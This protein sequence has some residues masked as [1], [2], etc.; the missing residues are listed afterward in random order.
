VADALTQDAVGAIEASVIPLPHQ[1]RALSRA[2]ANDRVRYLLADEVGLG[3]TIEAGFIMKELKLRGLVKRTLVI[4]PKGLV[5]QWVS[6][7]R[8]HLENRFSWCSRKICRV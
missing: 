2:I 3:K 8:F 4:A 7:M 5:N 1:I 6:E